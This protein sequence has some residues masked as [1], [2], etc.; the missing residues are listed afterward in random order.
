MIALRALE[1]ARRAGAQKA[2]SSDITRLIMIQEL[3]LH[4]NLR[5]PGLCGCQNAFKITGMHDGEMG[6]I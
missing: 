6:Q 1:I 2:A 4:G 3:F 5:H